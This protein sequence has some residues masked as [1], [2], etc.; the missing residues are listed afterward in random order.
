VPKTIEFRDL[1]E[2]H[3]KLL[4][5]IWQI[6]TTRPYLGAT[7][8]LIME[9]T[10]FTPRELANTLHELR[11]ISKSAY[12]KTVKG[13]KP[14]RYRLA[15]EHLVTQSDSAMVLTRFRDYP[16][17]KRKDGQ[18]PL[19]D[20]VSSTTRA[21]NLPEITVRDRITRALNRQYLVEVMRDQ[22]YLEMGD[23]LMCEER[24]LKLLAAEY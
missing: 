12:V 11:K 5:A 21:L 9:R 6:Q 10:G 8:K 16:A 1:Q 19:E 4:F 17:K 23:R 13:R 14:V 20:F 22:M 2:H 18:V 24:F 15:T 7:G 3:C